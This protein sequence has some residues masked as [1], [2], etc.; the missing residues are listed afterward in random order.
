MITDQ[1]NNDFK[2]ISTQNQVESEKQQKREKAVEKQGLHEFF[3]ENHEPWLI[4]SSKNNMGIKS[5]KFSKNIAEKNYKRSKYYDIKPIVI[6]RKPNELKK[7]KSKGGNPLDFKYSK[8]P[9]K[10]KM[11]QNLIDNIQVTSKIKNQE[12]QLAKRKIIASK[13]LETVT[14]DE[15]SQKFTESII[16][17]NI[18]NKNNGK[19]NI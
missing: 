5:K 15:K 7:E 16:N 9:E 11:K 19:Q 18:N 2:E 10:N 13:P 12:K 3:L 8:K 17:K 14:K 1:F 4:K 6:K